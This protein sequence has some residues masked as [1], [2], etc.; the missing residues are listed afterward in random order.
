VKPS[1]NML[2][3]LGQLPPF[4]FGPTITPALANYDGTYA[5][6]SGTKGQYR[7]QTTPVGSFAANGFGLHDMHGNVWEWCLDQWHESY[8]GAPTDGSAWVVNGNSSLRVLRGGSWIDD[9]R[10]CRSAC[11]NWYNPENGGDNLGFRLVISS[12]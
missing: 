4:H 6:G 8:S 3:E 7:Q 10:Y 5:Y 12:H 1:G 9:P 2:V 11:R